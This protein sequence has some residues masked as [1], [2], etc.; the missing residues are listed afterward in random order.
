[1]PLGSNASYSCTAIG[2]VFWRINERDVV[3]QIR[4][5]NLARF[6]I[7]APLPTANHSTV[8][9]TA[10]PTNNSTLTSVQ[11]RVEEVGGI[12]LLNSSVTVGLL[13][14]GKLILS[15]MSVHDIYTCCSR[16]LFSN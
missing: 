2:N 14:Y 9:I 12:T 4:V 5:D 1:M 13:V 3:G 15:I 16:T 8:I 7:F 10:T 11:C 6:N